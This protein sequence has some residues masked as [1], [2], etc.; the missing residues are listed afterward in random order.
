MS[1][2]RWQVIGCVTGKDDNGAVLM[3]PEMRESLLD[4]EE[5]ALEVD[6]PHFLDLIL[7]GLEE[8]THLRGNSSIGHEVI[9]GSIPIDSFLDQLLPVFFLSNVTDNPMRLVSLLPQLIDSL[10][11]VLLIATRDDYLHSLF[12]QILSDA[13]ANACG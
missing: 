10:I 6:V 5:S 3:F 4:E 2:D 12:G 9:N 13:L 1:D 11:D 7:L 8:V